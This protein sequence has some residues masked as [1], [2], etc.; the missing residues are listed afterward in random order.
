MPHLVICPLSLLEKTASEHNVRDII[1]LLSPDMQADR[2][3]GV[4][5]DRHL[6]LSLRDISAEIVDMESPAADHVAEM[7]D[8]AGSWN[9]EKPLLIH[10]WM[11]ISR[12][13]AGAYICALSLNP[14]L[15]E[16]ELALELRRRS[17]SATP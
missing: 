8:F 17:P 6:R 14:D 11:G 2:P 16:M 13:T 12:S 15:D 4:P 1:T 5:A 3:S 10:C 7:I 9:R